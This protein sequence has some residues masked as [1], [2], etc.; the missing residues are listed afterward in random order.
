[1]S[2]FGGLRSIATNGSAI[3]SLQYF[4][5][6]ETK[7]DNLEQNQP[8]S[9]AAVSGSVIEKRNLFLAEL[10]SGKW[11]KGCIKSDEKT[12]KPIFE[13]ADDFGENTACACA[14]MGN[15]FGRQSSG[16]ISLPKAT[17]ALGLKSTDC[18]FI[19][20]EINDRKS[21]LQE[22]AEIIETIFF[23]NSKLNEALLRIDKRHKILDDDVLNK[24]IASAPLVDRFVVAKII[25]DFKLTGRKIRI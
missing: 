2:L 23:D 13:N 19:Q 4:K 21:T 25:H 11:Q 12:G 16:K 8:L 1:M 22:D 17:K 18:R 24:E 7:T 6:M 20:R 15:L 10:R 3:G 5:I 14:I 9:L